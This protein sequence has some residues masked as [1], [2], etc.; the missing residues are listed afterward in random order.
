MTCRAHE[1]LM[2]E[3]Q[4]ACLNAQDRC[5][6]EDATALNILYTEPR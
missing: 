1:A 5:A 6:L 2:Q 3:H 4:R